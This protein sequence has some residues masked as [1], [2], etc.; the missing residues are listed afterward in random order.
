MGLIHGPP[1][2]N[3]KLWILIMGTMVL[4]PIWVLVMARPQWLTSFQ[5]S[6]GIGLMERILLQSKYDTIVKLLTF[7]VVTC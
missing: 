3:Q 5:S 6:K 4:N 2:I 1:K 7:S